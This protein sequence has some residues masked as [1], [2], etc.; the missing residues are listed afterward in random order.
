MTE[1]ETTARVALEV[2]NDQ[3]QSVRDDVESIGPVPVE[4]ED[5]RATSGGGASVADGGSDVLL[6][7]QEE[8]VDILD[9]I[10]DAVEAGGGGGGGGVLAVTGGDGGDDGLLQTAGGAALLDRIRS[11]LGKVDG[12][13]IG[14]GFVSSAL[15]AQVTGAFGAGG[16]APEDGLETDPLTNAITSE[17]DERFGREEAPIE[18]V[19]I[20][21]LQVPD[22]LSDLS[23][24]SPDWLGD[25]TVPDPSWLS[26]LNVSTPDWLSD[27]DVGSPD[28][29]SE[30]NVETPSWLSE[31]NVETPSWL[32]ELNVSTPDWLSDL[33]VSTPDWLPK[34]EVPEPDWLPQLSSNPRESK[35]VAQQPSSVTVDGQQIDL[36]TGVSE[37]FTSGGVSL[38]QDEITRAVEQR[39][40]E[41]GDTSITAEPTVNVEANG[42]SQR[43]VERQIKEA[44]EE[45][46]Q[47]AIQ[48]IRRQLVSGRGP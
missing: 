31:L 5:G 25:L 37:N 43:E 22:Q 35:T 11:G 27:L 39:Q 7:V 15:T 28:W 23:V 40:Q 17:L 33:D 13:R 42:V 24:P 30:L 47:Q 46:K 32:S 9:D 45:A 1:F 4:I 16:L 21:E 12:A 34:L 29:L 20:P 38:T 6:S 8:Q 10:R 48:E 3:L 44:T 36:P 14:T 19:D 2:P 26:E 18:Q 41:S